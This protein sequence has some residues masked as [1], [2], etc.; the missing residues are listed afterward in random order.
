VAVATKDFL[1]VMDTRE[2]LNRRRHSWKYTPKEDSWERMDLSLGDESKLSGIL[3]VSP[4]TYSAVYVNRDVAVDHSRVDDHDHE[5]KKESEE[6]EKEDTGTLYLV[7]VPA[8]YE[9]SSEC[10][11]HSRTVKCILNASHE[12]KWRLVEGIGY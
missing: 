12:D 7:R 8:S 9:P 10:I 1:L 5:E 3:A 2:K 4:F 11:I 6:Q